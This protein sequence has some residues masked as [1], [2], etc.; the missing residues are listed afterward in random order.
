M[1][2]M[3]C[4]QQRNKSA[5]VSALSDQSHQSHQGYTLTYLSQVDSSTSAL[6]TDP[7][8]IKGMSGYFILLSCFIKI[9][10]FNANSVDPDLRHLI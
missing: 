8:P 4:A 9:H 3:A 5:C 2:L 1:Y 7:F 10:A 6:W